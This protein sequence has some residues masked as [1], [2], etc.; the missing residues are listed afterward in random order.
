[1][2]IVLLCSTWC[3]IL[4]CQGRE[5]WLIYLNCF[6]V[7]ASFCL[8]DL[9]LYVPVNNLPVTPGRVFLG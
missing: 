9:I 4:F 1:M 7:I 3:R 6:Y 8:F 5:N 2:V